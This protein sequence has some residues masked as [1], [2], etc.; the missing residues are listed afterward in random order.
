MGRSN[1]KSG[2]FIYYLIKI[3]KFAIIA[4]INNEVLIKTVVAT[5]LITYLVELQTFSFEIN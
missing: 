1:I 5:V 3:C 4:L 2:T